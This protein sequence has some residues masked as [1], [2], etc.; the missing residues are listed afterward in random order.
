MAAVTG[1][2]IS[3]YQRVATIPTS[4]PQLDCMQLVPRLLLPIGPNFDVSATL[5]RLEISVGTNEA[6]SILPLEMIPSVKYSGAQ[7]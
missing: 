7:E 3:I 4:R 2:I 6:Y 1:P 5:L